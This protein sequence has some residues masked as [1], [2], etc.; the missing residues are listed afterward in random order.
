MVGGHQMHFFDMDMRMYYC[1]KSTTLGLCGEFVD[2][3]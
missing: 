1:S 2:D 3:V